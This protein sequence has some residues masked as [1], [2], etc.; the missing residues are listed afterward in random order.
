MIHIVYNLILLFVFIIGLPFVIPLVLISEK[1]RKT[2]L[3]RLALARLPGAIKHKKS[4]PYDERPIWLHA[5]SVGEVLSALPLAKAIRHAIGKRPLYFSAS[6]KTGHDIALKQVRDVADAIFFFP[7]DFI[8]SIRHM[9]NQINPGLVIIVETDIWPNFLYEMKKQCIPVLLVNARLSNS[10][11]SGY[12]K[13]GK[14]LNNLL[15]SFEK[16]CVQS[17][18]D[19]KRFRLLGIPED[20][21]IL[22]GNVKFDQPKPSDTEKDINTLGQSL[23]I[24]PEQ[25]VIIAGSTHSGEEEI[26]L[27]VY[28]KI[29]EKIPNLLLIIAPRDPGRARTV[30][31]LFEQ[32]G[33]SAI[34]MQEIEGH[35]NKNQMDVII[36]DAIGYL[37]KLYALGD[38]AFVGGSLVNCGGHNPLEPAALSKPVVFGPDMSDFTEI[39]ELLTQAEGAITVKDTK[40]L[41][42]AMLLLLTDKKKSLDMGGNAFK[43]FSSNKG[44]VSKTLNVIKKYL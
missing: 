39:A 26:L 15:L 40:S 7:Y 34:L 1:R 16:V 5:L 21:L 14:L 38:L 2:V 25:K 20:R 17:K 30:C 3:Q 29:K 44:A 4:Y 28:L 11:F 9:V 24:K 35:N 41:Q 12:K 8:P 33:F 23:H 13:L 19:G 37:N 27:N 10:S 36:I 31:R 22:T 42:S 6:T 18:E 43:V 32:E